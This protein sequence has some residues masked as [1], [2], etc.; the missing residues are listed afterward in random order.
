MAAGEAGRARLAQCKA[1]VASFGWAAA[2]EESFDS[3]IKDQ[4][5]NADHQRKEECLVQPVHAANRAKQ[6]NDVPEQTKVANCAGDGKNDDDKLV[7]ANVF[8]RVVN[9]LVKLLEPRC[10]FHA[11]G[12]GYAMGASSAAFS[13][14]PPNSG[15]QRWKLQ[16]KHRLLLLVGNFAVVQAFSI[17]LYKA[18]VRVTTKRM[19][20]SVGVR[21]WR[22]PSLMYIN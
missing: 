20:C 4:A 10:A 5:F 12:L 3:L 22:T 8:E 9:L 19:V 6:T 16:K 14:F 11:A 21:V 13:G 2:A 15:H 1:L 18:L 17:A 7:V